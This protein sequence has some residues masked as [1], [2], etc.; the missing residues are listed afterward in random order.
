MRIMQKELAGLKQHSKHYILGI[1][2]RF[3]KTGSIQD[4]RHSNEGRPRSVRKPD[5]I[6]DHEVRKLI[7]ETPQ[8]SLREVLGGVSNRVTYSRT[9]VH[10]ILRFDLHF[11]F[12][13]E[14]NCE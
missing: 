9:S 12:L 6:H 1:V 3:E 8:K 4:I 14:W 13:S 11:S 2:R 5:A 10:R 7:E